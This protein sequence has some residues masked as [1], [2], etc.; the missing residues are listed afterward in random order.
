[1]ICAVHTPEPP[2]TDSV[3]EVKDWVVEPEVLSVVVLG[4]LENELK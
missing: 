2:T 4:F 3:E 1:V